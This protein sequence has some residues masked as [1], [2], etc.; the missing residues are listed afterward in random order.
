MLKSIK[1]LLAG[2]R[3]VPT[4]ASSVPA[5]PAGYF[6]PLRAEQLLD[7]PTRR[8]CLQ[9]LWENSALPKDLYEQFY[10]QP[11][12][13]LV[14]LMQTLPAAQQGEYAREGGLV[15]VTL[16][17]TTFAV[18]LARGHMLPP[19][20]APEEQSAQNVL[21]SAVVFHAALF[22]YLPLLSQFDGELQSGR[23]WL[24]GITV[25]AEP[26]RFRFSATPPQS[27]LT[28]SQSALTAARLLPSACLAWLATLPV[29]VNALTLRIAGHPCPLPVIDELVQEAARLARGPGLSVSS[30][31]APVAA[32]PPV[33]AADTAA[34]LIS[35]VALQSAVSGA[36]AAD[37]PSPADIP[38]PTEDGTTPTAGVL[39]SSAFDVPVNDKPLA[40]MTVTPETVVAVDDDTRALLSLMS[41]GI[42][43]VAAPV[44]TA[45]S[46]GDAGPDPAPA[47]PVVTAPPATP[48][49][50][51]ED[52]SS[53]VVVTAPLPETMAPAATTDN[54]P[55]EAF[56]QWLADGLRSGEIP[57]NS[58]EARVHLVS[59]FAFLCVPDIFHLYL[60]GPGGGNERRSAL[61]KAVEK[62]GRHRVSRG[63]RFFTAHLYP[64]DAREGS[65]RRING[66]LVKF[67]L[68]YRGASAPEDSRLLV[69][70]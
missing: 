54:P 14:S 43:D 20:A 36:L 33:L 50:P 58:A 11:L 5:G 26:Y 38:T 8:K 6:M 57:V 56:W 34:P 63:Q 35:A 45:A 3:E 19:G 44:Q 17:T 48:P 65:Y 30:L 55:G 64:D 40:E 39:L 28:A 1:A 70:P 29:A 62:L 49:Q 10:L 51:V 68:L 15:D 4:A 22:H 60:K 67:S 2:S 52:A 23:A 32:E 42:L 7:T 12:R 9:Q 66:Y 37:S 47:P 69:I 18:R 21:W 46:D 27:A 31:P 61:Q 16:Y 41:V 25:P 24:P 13:Q 53:N 59:G